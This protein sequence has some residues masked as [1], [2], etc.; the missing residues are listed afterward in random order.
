MLNLVCPEF[1]EFEEA[2]RFVQGRYLLTERTSQDW[3]LRAAK[4]GDSE[5]LIA[6]EGAAN[7]YHGACASCF[8][9]AG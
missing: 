3:R 5:V 2:L 9:A 7:S 1:D 4:L 8:G 6:H